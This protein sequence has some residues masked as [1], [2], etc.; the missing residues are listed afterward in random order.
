M[1]N[2]IDLVRNNP[3]Y[4]KQFSCNDLLFLNYDCPVELKK[5]AKWSEHN[6]IYY[7][8]TG[9]KTLHTTESSITLTTGSLAFIKKGACVVEQFFEEPFCIVVFVMP[10]AFINTFLKHYAPGEKPAGPPTPPIIPIY[11]DAMIK[12]FYQSIIPYFVN[13]DEV[14]ADILELKFKELLLYILHNPQN[15]ELRN[16][17]LSLREETGSPLKEIMENNYAYNLKIEEYAR[18]TN[19]SVSSFKRDFQAIYKTTPGRW[20]MDKKLE[21]AKKLLF[22][23]DARISDV[24][25][26]SGFENT[27]HFS[28]MFRQKTGVTPMEYRKAGIQK[29]I[30]TAL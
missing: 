15:K 30:V 21:R 20:L 12:G 1:I 29:S 17:L 18:L 27:A 9:R 25:F 26:D 19:R 11:D 14:P 24:A 28:R 2:Y 4:F 10:D 16:H 13:A 7:V 22:Q 3:G 6:Y 5:V 23:T 8:L